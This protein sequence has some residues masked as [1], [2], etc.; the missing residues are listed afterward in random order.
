M[1]DVIG[2]ADVLHVEPRY[3]NITKTTDG[4]VLVRGR[5]ERAALTRTRRSRRSSGSS[6][7]CPAHPEN[8]S[9]P[10]ATTCGSSTDRADNW[11]PVHGPD[12]L[13]SSGSPIVTLAFAATD[14]T[15]GTYAAGTRS[16]RSRDERWGA[17][18][19]STS[20]EAFPSRACNDLPSDPTR[21]QRALRGGVG[22]RRPH[23]YR[24]AD[25]LSPF[26]TWLDRRRRD[27][28]RPINAVLVDPDEPKVLYAGSDLGLFRA[29]TPGASWAFQLNGIPRVAIYDLVADAGTRALVRVHTGRGRSV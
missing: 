3:L 23:L 28:R 26:L 9:S 13:E 20:P 10:A 24:T 17:R 29:S 6:S 15:C 18:T 27:P 5:D 8:A 14:T 2:P 16:T 1:I 4:R 19:G 21:S 12:P 25:A 22:I 11:S 7:A